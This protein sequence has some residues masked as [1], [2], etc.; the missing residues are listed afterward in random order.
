[1]TEA[2]AG[3]DGGGTVDEGI[4]GNVGYGLRARCLGQRVGR[5]YLGVR[6]TRVEEEVLKGGWG[7]GGREG[8]GW[9]DGAL[10]RLWN[11]WLV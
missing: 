10:C 2:G 3:E 11:R 6:R 7:P 5:W 4:G 8:K 1:M 9:G